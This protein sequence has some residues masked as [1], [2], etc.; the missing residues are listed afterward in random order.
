LGVDHILEHGADL[1][2]QPDPFCG[3]CGGPAGPEGAWCDGCI[4]E[5]REYTRRLYREVAL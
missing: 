5:C 1:E 2:P 4:R 3:R